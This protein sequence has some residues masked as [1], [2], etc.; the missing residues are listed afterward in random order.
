MKKQVRNGGAEPRVAAPEENEAA[1]RERKAV[2]DAHAELLRSAPAENSI[3]PAPELKVVDAASVFAAGGAAFVPAP[4]VENLV[5]DQLTPDHPTPRQIDAETLLAAAPA[6][7]YAVAASV[8]PAAPI[9]FPIA[10]AA[11]DG[12]GRTATWLGVLLMALGLLTLLGSSRTLRE[13]VLLRD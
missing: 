2:V 13:A 10:E 4:S 5:T 11:D 7:S 1:R 6:A 12:R 9:A 8:P 3:R